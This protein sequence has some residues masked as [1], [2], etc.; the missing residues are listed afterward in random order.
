MSA[1][2]GWTAV[3]SRWSAVAPRRKAI[4]AL[5]LVFAAG[6]VGGAAIED[7]ADE[8]ERPF[9]TAH[10]DDDED[11]DSEE[12]IL[13]NLDL[14]PEQ[15]ASIEQVF[16]AREDRLESYWDARLPDLDLLI[17][18]SRQEIR[19]ILTPAQR[20]I[21]DSGLARLGIDERLELIE[22]HDD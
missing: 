9:F 1:I 4:L 19:G 14:T 10:R 21:Y 18:S 5:G 2:P 20:A 6:L 17:D 13:A 12:T 16:E 15:Q 22:D 3:R 8:I 11:A 7:I